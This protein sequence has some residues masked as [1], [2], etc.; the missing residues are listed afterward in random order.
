MEI[1]ETAPP[2]SVKGANKE[3]LHPGSRKVAD[4]H[5]TITDI[6]NAGV[7]VVSLFKSSV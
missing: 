5:V 2:S 6:K 4:I 3:K 7:L 1:S